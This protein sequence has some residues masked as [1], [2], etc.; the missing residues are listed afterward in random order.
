MAPKKNKERYNVYLDKESVDIVKE[1]IKGTGLSL[2]S[3]LDLM[4]CIAADRIM[5]FWAEDPLEQF[6]YDENDL[7]NKYCNILVAHRVLKLADSQF[8]GIKMSQSQ[9]KK[10]KTGDWHIALDDNYGIRINP[11]KKED[12]NHNKKL[13]KK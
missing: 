1:F 11:F 8:K 9:I 4:T 13:E 10:L 6:D 7:K 3:Y 12:E 2:S 5:D